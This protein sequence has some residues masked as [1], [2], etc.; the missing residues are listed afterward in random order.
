MFKLSL[1]V[2]PLLTACT[3][4][5]RSAEW[6]ASTTSKTSATEA[7]FTRAAQSVCGLNGA[8]ERIDEVTVQCFTHRGQ[9]AGKAVPL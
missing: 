4:Q 3:V 2:L 5:D 1:I 9:K 8:W 7:R 6:S